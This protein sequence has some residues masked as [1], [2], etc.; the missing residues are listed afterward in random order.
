MVREQYNTATEGTHIERPENQYVYKIGIYGWRKRCLY[1]FVLLLLII[2]L[3]NF[4]L[5]IWIL[6]VMWFSPVEN[7]CSRGWKR[8]G[9]NFPGVSIRTTALP[10]YFRLLISRTII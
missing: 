5:A 4:A 6:K 10:T 9:K 3:V 7:R 2:L 1:L 8:Q